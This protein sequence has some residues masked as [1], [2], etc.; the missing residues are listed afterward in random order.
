MVTRRLEHTWKPLESRRL[1]HNQ[2]SLNTAHFSLASRRQLNLFNKIST[3]LKII[4]DIAYFTNVQAIVITRNAPNHRLTAVMSVLEDVIKY[5]IPI[6]RAFA[7]E[8]GFSKL[9]DCDAIQMV[10]F[11]YVLFFA[12]LAQKESQKIK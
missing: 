12:T 9:T 10:E 11:Y 8:D 2:I 6:K 7:H 1:I 5:D 4:K 3:T